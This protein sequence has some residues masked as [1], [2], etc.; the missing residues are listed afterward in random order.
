VWS[1]ALLKFL[2]SFCSGWWINPSWF[3][4]DTSRGIET[5]GSKI[6]MRSTVVVLDALVYV[7]ALLLFV[8]TWQGSRSK[9]T[10]VCI[11]LILG[12]DME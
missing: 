6:F 10:Q 7:P 1:D 3:A 8:R 5:E 12:K 9:R 4:L 11:M 2:I